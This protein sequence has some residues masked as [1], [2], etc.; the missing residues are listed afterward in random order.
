MPHIAHLLIIFSPYTLLHPP[1]SHHIYQESSCRKRVSL[2]CKHN[3]H[4]PGCLSRVSGSIDSG[5]KCHHQ[6]VGSSAHC[7]QCP[8]SVIPVCINWPS[9]GHQPISARCTNVSA[10]CHHTVYGAHNNERMLLSIIQICICNKS[11]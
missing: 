10:P 9:V 11:F 5:N 3:T 8:A 1:P 2:C 7:T 4:Q 6:E